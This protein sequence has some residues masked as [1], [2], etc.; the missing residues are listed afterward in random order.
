MNVNQLLPSL[1]L[2]NDPEVLLW[3]SKKDIRKYQEKTDKASR[4]THQFICVN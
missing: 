2:F 3:H 1:M 4:K